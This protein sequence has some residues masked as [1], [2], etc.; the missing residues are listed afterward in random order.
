MKILFEDNTSDENNNELTNSRQMKLT[1]S[2][3]FKTNE[4][5]FPRLLD[6]I[7]TE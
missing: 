6:F 3:K 5:Q 4:W 2:R 7:S 1:N